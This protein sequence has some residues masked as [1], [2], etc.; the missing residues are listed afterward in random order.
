[1]IVDYIDAYRS[2]FFGRPDLRRTY[3]ARRQHRP[4][5]TVY[6][7]NKRVY[8]VRKMWHAMKR[9]GHDMDRDQVA[10]LMRICGIAGAVRGKHR[11]ITTKRD[12]R[13]T[14]APRSDRAE[15]GRAAASGP[16]VGRRLHLRV[17]AGRIRLYRVLRRRLLPPDSGLAGD[18]HK[19]HSVGRRR[20]RTSTVH[21]TE[22]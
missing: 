9:A 18:D 17:D 20:S 13:G 1:V 19:G 5:H 14:A 11:T 10:R 16:V 12:D 21:P 3:R 15:L 8:G 2:R 6:V 7:A 4:G 22:D